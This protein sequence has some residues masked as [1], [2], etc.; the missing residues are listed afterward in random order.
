M[1]MDRIWT[2]NDLYENTSADALKSLASGIIAL[3][4]LGAF[5]TQSQ[6]DHSAKVK[7]KR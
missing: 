6:I 1:L 5:E 7:R 4:K 2:I 3:E